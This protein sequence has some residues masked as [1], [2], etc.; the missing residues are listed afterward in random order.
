MTQSPMALQQELENYET[1]HTRR[2]QIG[3]SLAKM[4]DPRPGV[5]V[6][7]GVPD[8]AWLP[9]ATDG[10]VKITRTSHP[11]TPDD[12][13]KVMHTQHFNVE[14]FYIAKYLVTYGPISSFCRSRR[15]V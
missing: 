6:K 5:A 4:G 12:K 14:P 2:L 15:W 1:T 7:D 13:P 9:I 11:D 10:E 8:I 3:E